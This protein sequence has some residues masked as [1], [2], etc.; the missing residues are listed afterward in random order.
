M[1]ARHILTEK[2]LTHAK[3]AP[4]GKRYT[5]WDAVTPSL[6]VRISDTGRKSFI[7]Q[8]RVNGRMLRLKLGEFPALG[9]GKAREKAEEPLKLITKGIDPRHSTSPVTATRQRADSFEGA[10]EKYIKREVEKHRRPRTQDEFIR[11][12]R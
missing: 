10:V 8:R 12:L 1:P 2:Q 11:P 5:L 6:G 7:I 3:A 9:L 4:K